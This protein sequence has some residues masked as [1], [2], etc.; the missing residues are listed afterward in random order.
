[1]KKLTSATFIACLIFVLYLFFNIDFLRFLH[2]IIFDYEMYQKNGLEYINIF[3]AIIFL[4][5]YLLLVTYVRKDYI[6]N[7]AY[8]RTLLYRYDKKSFVYKLFKETLIK[9]I[10]INRIFGIVFFSIII[11]SKD[12]IIFLYWIRYS[13]SILFIIL[14][15]HLNHLVDFSNQMNIYIDFFFSML[16]ISDLLM[17]HHLITFSNDFFKE[18][19]MI[20][21]IILMIIIYI[22][23]MIRKIK[24]RSEIQ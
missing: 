16:F 2:L 12:Y 8:I 1:M 7:E 24:K 22:N 5:L 15:Y 9:I 6:F 10:K 17:K 18:I 3:Y 14:F 4:S 13:L 11:Y 20:F 23:Y 21:L 19:I